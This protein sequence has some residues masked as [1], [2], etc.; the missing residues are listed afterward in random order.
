MPT[1]LPLVTVGF[2]VYNGARY[3]KGAIESVLAQEYRHLEIIISDNGSTDDTPEICARYASGDS[4][5]RVVRHEVNRGASANFNDLV[6]AARG[7]Y[8]KWMAHDDLCDPRLVG[9]CVEVLEREPSVVLCYAKT[10]LIDEDGA[11]LRICD[12]GFHFRDASPAVRFGRY[13]RLAL[14]MMSPVFGV[15]RADSLRASC[16]L[17]RY[18]SSDMVLMGDLVLRGEFHEVAESLFL[19][20]YHAG[21]S[22]RANPGFAERYR[23]F[24]TA[25][26]GRARFVRW[27]W[28][29]AFGRVVSRAPIPTSERAR[30]MAHLARW[31]WENHGGLVADV[32]LALGARRSRTTACA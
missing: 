4:R 22:V 13:L 23:W 28:L 10:T 18:P 26:R 2:P 5:I 8:F 19:R 30:A 31:G 20:R 9:A 24:D 15:H 12:D 29:G 7:R 32:K 16:L 21:M 27:R 17:G 3:L 11:V 1:D 14:G 6:L 25:Y